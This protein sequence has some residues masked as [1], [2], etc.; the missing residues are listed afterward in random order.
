MLESY[1][2]NIVPLLSAPMTRYALAMPGSGF[3]TTRVINA[4]QLFSMEDTSSF[5]EFTIWLIR[6]DFPSVPIIIGSAEREGAE[7]EL[8]TVG[9]IPV[10]RWMSAAKSCA[11]R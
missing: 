2:A 4:S 10:T 8:E 3:A 6:E 9:V 5:V 1:R 11:A 7:E